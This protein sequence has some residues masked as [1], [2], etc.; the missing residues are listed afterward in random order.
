MPRVP[1]RAVPTVH[2]IDQILL[3]SIV[4]TVRINHHLCTALRFSVCIN[5]HERVTHRGHFRLRLLK[6]LLCLLCRWS[7]RAFSS[8]LLR[9]GHRMSRCVTA[10]VAMRAHDVAIAVAFESERFAFSTPT[11]FLRPHL[12][13]LYPIVTSPRL[14]LGVGMIPAREG[15][16][17]V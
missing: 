7:L 11:E 4:V 15:L 12:G 1:A 13:V 3:V 8:V 2:S 16:V 14:L 5:L 9:C 10:G 6:R 17:A